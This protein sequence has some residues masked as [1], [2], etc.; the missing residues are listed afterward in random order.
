MSSGIRFVRMTLFPEVRRLHGVEIALLMALQFIAADCHR[1][2]KDEAIPI[3][4]A[5]GETVTLERVSA[6]GGD[7]FAVRAAAGQ[8]LYVELDVNCPHCGGWNSEASGKIQV[9]PPEAAHR[10]ELPS[11]PLC[12]SPEAQW[13]NVLASSGTY[14]VLVT[15]RPV[16]RYHLE[17][18]L[19][20]AHDPR[21]DPGMTPD[22]IFIGE[23]LI[24]HGKGLT[25]REYQPW[26]D[27]C[28]IP[29]VDDTLPAH[30]RFADK[31]V[32]LGVMSLE[33]LKRAGYWQELVAEME[34]TGGVAA[35][36][37]S[38]DFIDSSLT[39]WGR[40]ESF[41]G[42][43]WRGW[44][45]L[46]QYSQEHDEL[47]NP[48]T[49]MFVAVSYDHHCLIWLSVDIEDVDAPPDLFRLSDKESARIVEDPKAADAYQQK[50]N[51]ALT[52]APPSSFNPSLN[53]LDSAVRALDLR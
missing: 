17:V 46:G 31:G 53:Q 35:T 3:R 51:A 10:A 33:G 1:R 30:L 25:L 12:A 5:A 15:V 47:R 52:K 21:L 34:R 36:P 9:L 39:Y 37:P 8:T 48:L 18:T 4:P 32:W 2:V 22:R 43:S 49:Y 26:A 23:G 6:K 16:K 38:S 7:E 44:R 19:M 41:E 27:D 11:Q 50:V 40:L 24:P 45:W 28:G 20:D 14:H 29:D 42:K 13:M